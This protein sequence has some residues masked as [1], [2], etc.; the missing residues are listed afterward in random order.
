MG[1]LRKIV[2][3]DSNYLWGIKTTY[4]LEDLTALVTFKAFLDGYKSTPMI[5]EFHGPEDP[6]INSTF[7]ADINGINLNK[8][9]FCR[10]L[11]KYGLADGWLPESPNSKSKVYTNGKDILG[12][13]G[14]NTNGI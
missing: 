7:T 9:G 4:N 3:D 1:K 5:V 12:I 10:Q 13:L 2:I 6:R 8:P 11:I 14:H